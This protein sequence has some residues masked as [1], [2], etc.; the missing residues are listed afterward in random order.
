MFLRKYCERCMIYQEKL[1]VIRI[2][3]R[4]LD[5]YHQVVNF[6]FICFR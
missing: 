6:Q 3:Q 1:P 4:E 2:L 5:R